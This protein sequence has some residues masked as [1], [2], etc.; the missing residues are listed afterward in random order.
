M[1]LRH[2][3]RLQYFNELASTTREYF[4]NYIRN[5]FNLSS[6]CKVL[7]IGCGEG[8]NL[9]P[10]AE[11]GCKVKGID[12]S[13]T[14]IEQAQE[15]FE[16]YNTSGEFVC[17][18]FITADKP[19]SEEDRFDIILVHDVIEHIEPP[20][21]SDFIRN[22]KPFLRQN[23]II[24]FGFPAWQ[25]PFGGHQQITRGFASKLPFIHLLPNFMYKWLLKMSAVPQNAVDEL[26]SIKRA[27]MPIERFEKIISTEGFSITNRSLWFI[28]PHYKQ[29]FGLKPRR[30]WNW[31]SHIPYFRN[32]Y[33][34][35]VFYILKKI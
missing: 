3:N 22:I 29:K 26:M 13:K 33:T 19:N 14:R 35:S 24:F 1:Q 18:N 25:N 27:K 8:G 23:G 2:S 7:E 12:I 30:V 32:Y 20:F 10:F 21:K 4:I 5:Y 34:T 17:K 28:N 9:L 31:A 15:F 6:K 11:M 16:Y